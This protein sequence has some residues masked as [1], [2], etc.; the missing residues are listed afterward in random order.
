M[1]KKRVNLKYHC[2]H[3]NVLWIMFLLLIFAFASCE[4]EDIEIMKPVSLVKLEEN[5]HRQ[6]IRKQFEPDALPPIP[7]PDS[8][9]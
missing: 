6:S 7:Q 1:D 9:L 2:M 5:M 3:K 8:R 4:Q